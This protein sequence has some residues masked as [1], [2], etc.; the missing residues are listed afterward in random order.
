VAEKHNFR[1]IQ[2]KIPQ[3]SDFAKKWD[4]NPLPHGEIAVDIAKTFE[5][6]LHRK[7]DSAKNDFRRFPQ[8]ADFRHF[9]PFPQFKL[10]KF[11]VSQ[12]DYHKKT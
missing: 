2:R 6:N 3:K 10:G 4:S 9:R 8:P 7:S 1:S 5:Q 11:A 12:L